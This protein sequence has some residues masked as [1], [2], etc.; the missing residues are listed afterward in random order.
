MGPRLGER[1][2]GGST[3]RYRVYRKKSARRD[4]RLQPP[5][6]SYP[7]ATT[8]ASLPPAVR[9]ILTPRDASQTD[10]RDST[11]ASRS[12]WVFYSRSALQASGFRAKHLPNVG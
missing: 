4:K 1:G 5:L 12:V 9:Q 10:T 11:I 7:P 2:A 3:S 8:S 6:I